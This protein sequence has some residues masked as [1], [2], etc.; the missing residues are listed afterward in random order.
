MAFYWVEL[1]V[2]MQRW[3]LLVRPVKPLGLGQISSAFLIGYAANNVMPARLGELVRADHL[4]RRHGLSRLAAASTIVVE[5]AFD[6]AAVTTCAA[7]GG[8]LLLRRP[9]SSLPP[10]ILVAVAVAAVVLAAVFALMSALNAPRAAAVARRFERLRRPL[11][12]FADGFEALRRPALLALVIGLSVLA[13]IGNLLA[14]ACLLRAVG[15]SPDATLLLLV[16]GVSGFAVALPSAPA[17]VG[18]LQFAFVAALTAVGPRSHRRLRGGAAHAGVPVRKRDSRGR[19]GVRGRRHG[20][21]AGRRWLAS[22]PCL[23]CVPHAS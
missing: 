8:W 16:I 15:L 10:S 5:R 19:L 18:T 1:G 17:G 23:W 12:R 14:T 2:R 3:R 20:A 22:T 21:E 7:V 6:L 13:W 4:G 9:S 11:A